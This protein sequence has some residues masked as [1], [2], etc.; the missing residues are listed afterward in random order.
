MRV[1]NEGEHCTPELVK[2]V[3]DVDVHASI[4]P[5]TGKPFFMPF[6]GVEKYDAHRAGY[7]NFPRL[8][9]GGMRGIS[10]LVPDLLHHKRCCRH[11]FILIR[12]TS[13]TT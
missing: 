1:L 11:F 10:E 12:K 4:N 13:I 7:C 8:T 5:L 6:R 9:A 3:F 2:A